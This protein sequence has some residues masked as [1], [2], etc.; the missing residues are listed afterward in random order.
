MKNILLG[1]TLGA[2]LIALPGLAQTPQTKTYPLK[3]AS[4]HDVAPAPGGLVWWTAQ[5]DGK[6]GVLDPK[7]GATKLV[8]LGPN[9]APHGVIQSKDGKAWITDGGRTRSPL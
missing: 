8:E 5:G 9:S 4:I 3:G 6:L 1:A 2:A 7:T